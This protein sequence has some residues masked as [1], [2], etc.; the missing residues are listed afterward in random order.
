MTAYRLLVSITAFLLI[1]LFVSGMAYDLA[2]GLPRAARYVARFWP[3][4]WTAIPSLLPAAASTL[5]MSLY[6]TTMALATALPLT[7]LASRGLVPNLLVYLTS[8]AWAALFRASPVVML[9][10]VFVAAVGLGPKAGIMGI[11]LH[12]VGVFVK[13]FSEAFESADWEVMEAAFIDGAN[14]WQAYTLVLIPM[15]ANAVLSF[16][17]YYFEA[18]FRQATFLA[19]VGA[20]GIGIE[21]SGALGRF[22]YG[23]AGAIVVLIL[24]VALALDLSSRFL[25]SKVL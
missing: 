24:G 5:A 18:N 1:G 13:Y 21:L 22:D 15:E 3:V 8:R 25:R 7:L 19:M 12:T 23:R 4:D 14:R 16:L 10:I 11:W 6:G 17:L 2:A 20:G 9:G